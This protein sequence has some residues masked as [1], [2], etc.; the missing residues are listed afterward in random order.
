MPKLSDIEAEQIARKHLCIPTLETRNSD[1]LDFHEVSVWSLKEA[2]Q[3]AF[4]LG[5]A[6]ATSRLF[7]RRVAD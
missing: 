1:S 4:A 3:A 7:F 2:L 6:E 5:G